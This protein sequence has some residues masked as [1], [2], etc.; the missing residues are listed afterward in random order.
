MGGV[1]CD[2]V[3]RFKAVPAFAPGRG[4]WGGLCTLES[5]ILAIPSKVGSGSNHIPLSC[6][7]SGLRF[8]LAWF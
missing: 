5:S 7:L 6:F 8:K 2:V 1:V 3:P 4:P